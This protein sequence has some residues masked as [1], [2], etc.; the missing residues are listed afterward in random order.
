MTSS[1]PES[2]LTPY[3]RSSPLESAQPKSA[4]IEGRK[5]R[6]GLGIKFTSLHFTSP[7]MCEE[8]EPHFIVEV[9]ST[10]ATTAD[11]SVLQEIHEHE[12]AHD[13]LPHQHLMDMGYVDAE[14]LAENQMRYHVD[15]VGPVLPDT[16]LRIQRSWTF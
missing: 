12:A 1:N 16:C 15:V 14:V 5:I 7:Q 4:K 13:L 11:G 8:D 3:M 6:S 10:A 9:V 2:N